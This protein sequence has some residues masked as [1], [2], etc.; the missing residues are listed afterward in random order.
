MEFNMVSGKRLPYWLGLIA[1]VL[2]LL[3]GLW[4]VVFGLLCEWGHP[5]GML[6]H[7]LAPGVAY[8]AA[9]WLA[10]RWPLF[11]GTVL[12]LLG[13]YSVWFF[14]TYRNFFTLLLVSLPPI[15]AGL[16]FLVSYFIGRR[17]VA[18]GIT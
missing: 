7:I 14:H 1:L 3:C 2:I 9:G 8:L 13:A 5:V 18:S 11:G 10:W 4:W 15:I 12:V 17:K 6:M 16:L